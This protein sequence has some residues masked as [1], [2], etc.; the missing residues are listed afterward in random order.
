MI[1]T[2][3]GFPEVRG[4]KKIGWRGG[5]RKPFSSAHPKNE[6]LRKK[7]KKKRFV[8]GVPKLLKLKKKMYLAVVLRC[9]IQTGILRSAHSV[10]SIRVVIRYLLLEIWR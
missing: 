6:F 5:S 1:I 4:K 10:S 8:K 2:A 9:S 3:I 7:K